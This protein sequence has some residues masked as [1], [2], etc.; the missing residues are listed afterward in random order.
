MKPCSQVHRLFDNNKV[1]AVT[2][3]TSKFTRQSRI[4]TD[5]L[6]LN[7]RLEHHKKLFKLCNHSNTGLLTFFTT[8]SN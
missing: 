2:L 3:G 5:V 7:D 4:M 8:T 1:Y 6:I